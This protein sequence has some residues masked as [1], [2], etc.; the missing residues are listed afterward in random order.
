LLLLTG[1]DGLF[2]YSTLTNDESVL[3]GD[4]DAAVAAV[5]VFDNSPQQFGQPSL[6]YRSLTSP[7]GLQAIKVLPPGML[8]NAANQ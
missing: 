7:S 6:P 8:R 4:E 5:L 3:V 1:F 2:V